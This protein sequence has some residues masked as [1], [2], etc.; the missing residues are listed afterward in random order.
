MKILKGLQ[1]GNNVVDKKQK[2]ANKMSNCIVGF[3]V[4]FSCGFSHAVPSLRTGTLSEI[5]ST[6]YTNYAR[7][8]DRVTH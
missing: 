1:S 3:G 4:A 2:N 8:I 7:L 5:H 6:T